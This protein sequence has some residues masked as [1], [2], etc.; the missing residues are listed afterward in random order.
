MFLLSLSIIYPKKINLTPFVT[1]T[2]SVLNEVL[3]EPWRV[4]PRFT[5]HIPDMIIQDFY[6]FRQ[7]KVLFMKTFRTGTTKMFVV[8][9]NAVAGYLKKHSLNSWKIRNEFANFFYLLFH[10]LYGKGIFIVALLCK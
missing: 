10:I 7:H 4:K 3:L 2:L 5:I 8:M 9:L 1:F 6:P